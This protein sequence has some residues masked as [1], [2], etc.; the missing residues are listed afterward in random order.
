MTGLCGQRK[1]IQN[2]HTLTS[3]SFLRQVND[4]QTELSEHVDDSKTRIDSLDRDVQ[5]FR[6]NY[7]TEMGQCRLA[8]DGLDRRLAVLEGSCVHLDSF[9]DGLEK[10]EEGF[11]RHVTVLWN[12][13]HGLNATVTSQGD[14]INRIQNVQLENVNN[15]IQR[16]NSSVVDLTREFHSFVQQDFM[17]KLRFLKI[18]VA[19]QWQRVK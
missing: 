12:D 5:I 6:S 8:T 10:I 9:S 11:N 13:V 4:L 18:W 3:F 7:V 14:L 2:T 16:L 17:G 19:Y 1:R 15:K